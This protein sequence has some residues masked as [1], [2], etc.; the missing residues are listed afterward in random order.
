[1]VT[2]FEKFSQPDIM[3]IKSV[4]DAAEIPY[5]FSGE[6]FHMMGVMPLPARLL[7]PSDKKEQ[8]LEILQSLQFI[9]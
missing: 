4:L 2:A 5:H 1:M 6:F 3:F 8:T 7:I 9:D